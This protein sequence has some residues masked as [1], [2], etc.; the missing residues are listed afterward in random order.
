MKI[1]LFKLSTCSP[2]KAVSKILTALHIKYTEMI[3]DENEEADTLADK[4]GICS[5]PTIIITDNDNNEVDRIAGVK[6]K[7]EFK[8]LLSKYND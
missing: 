4:Y 6:S 1:L 5:V 7:E 8:E 3:V 2:C